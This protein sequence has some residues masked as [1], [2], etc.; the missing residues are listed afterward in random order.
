MLQ[1]SGRSLPAWFEDFFLGER[2]VLPARTLT[3]KM[4][5]GFAEISGELHPLH[6][7][8]EYSHE[9]GHPGILAHGFMLVAQT[10]AGA[11]LFPFMVEELLVGLVD[12]A[13]RFV[14]PAY[15]DD[16][17]HPLLQVTELA[18]NTATGVVTL[19]STVHNQRRELVMEGTQRWLLRKRP[20]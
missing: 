13:S 11:V 4:F 18:P 2:F 8:A 7:D 1:C 5:H 16:T 12:Q 6:L 9:R 15:V 3:E 20:S 17:V 19:R 10:V 14:R